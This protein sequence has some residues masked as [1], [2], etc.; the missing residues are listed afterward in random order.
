M[1]IKKTLGTRFCFQ[2][3]KERNGLICRLSGSHDT[4]FNQQV[5]HFFKLF[6]L[7]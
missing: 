2:I 6:F 7:G 4:E 3:V 1:L 5:K